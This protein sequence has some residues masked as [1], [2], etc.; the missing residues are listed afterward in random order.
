MYLNKTLY[1][2]I[3]QWNYFDLLNYLEYV[4]FGGTTR[5]K[6]HF[7]YY[8]RHEYSAGLLMSYDVSK[9]YI[10]YTPNEWVCYY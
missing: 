3:F 5:K 4:E 10:L 2:R 8:V 6:Q 1:W 9:Y 7:E